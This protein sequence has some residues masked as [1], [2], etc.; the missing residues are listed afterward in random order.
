MNILHFIMENDKFNKNIKV[1]TREN[2]AV[3]VLKK[4]QQKN[5]YAK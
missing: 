1:L 5:N 4:Q 3:V 2:I